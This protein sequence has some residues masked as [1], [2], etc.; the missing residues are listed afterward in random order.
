VE[1]ATVMARIVCEAELSINS[2]LMVRV[3]LGIVPNLFWNCTPTHH[4]DASHNLLVPQHHQQY[5]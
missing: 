4:I 2:K 3:R 5:Y 1:A